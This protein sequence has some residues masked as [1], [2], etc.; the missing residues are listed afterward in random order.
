MT[1]LKAFIAKHSVAIYFT[2]TF[3][4]SWGGALLAIGGSGG[5][6]GTTPASDPRFAYA[7][8]AMLAGPSLTGILMTTLAHG[9]SG[10]RRLLTRLGAWRAGAVWYAVALL[11]APVVMT[12]TLLALS[13]FSPAFLPGIV[14][15]DDQTSLLLVSFAVGLSAGLFE[16]LGWTG[17]AIPMLRRRHSV[18]VTGLI[19]GMLW[20]AWHLLP[21]VWASRAASGELAMPIYLAGTAIGVLVGYLTAFRVLMVWVYDHTQSL[22]VT[23]LMHVSLT[24]SLLIL[25]PLGMSGAH[26]LAFSFAFAAAVWVVVGAIA[27]RRGGHLERPP[28]LRRPAPARQAPFRAASPIDRSATSA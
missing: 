4:I 1:G 20:S 2:L 27:S 13:T 22:L 7:L 11:T 16:E 3:V 15:T 12:M 18:L 8:I 28:A 26:L 25:N 21:N 23:M 14:I 17:F 24:A 10:R 19:A 6:R 5:M 9:R